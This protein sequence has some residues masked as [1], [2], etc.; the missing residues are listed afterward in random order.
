MHSGCRKE[1]SRDVLCIKSNQ[2][3]IRV[4][5]GQIFGCICTLLGLA[6]FWVSLGHVM[7]AEGRW[8]A[9]ISIF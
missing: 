8:D 7:L 9:L 5:C 3:G 4:L 6:Y 2:L 1:N